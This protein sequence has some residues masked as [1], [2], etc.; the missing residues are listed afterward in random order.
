MQKRIFACMCLMLMLGIFARAGVRG[1]SGSVLKKVN[2]VE[3]IEKRIEQKFPY[4]SVPRETFGFV[5]KVLSPH[6]LKGYIKDDDGFI[7][8]INCIKFD[9]FKAE[10]KVV[11]LR[12]VCQQCGADFAYISYPSKS[13]EGVKGNRYGVN[14]NSEELRKSFLEGLDL[15]GV[16]YLDIRELLENDGYDVKTVFYKTDHHWT[17]ES[18]MYAANAIVDYLNRNFGYG[19]RKELLSKEKFTYRKY[20]NLWLGETGRLLSKTWTGALDD[21]TAIKPN[22]E[23]SLTVGKYHGE[24]K[25]HGDFSLLIDENGYSGGNDLYTYSAHYSYR[26]GGNMQSIHNNR[27]E[28][29][30]LLI[31]KDSFSVVVIPFLALT[32]SEVVSWDMRGNNQS[33][34]EFIRENDFDIVLLAY[35]DFWRYDMWG[36]K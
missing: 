14:S 32:M 4:K 15:Q 24:E 17:T 30:K 22:Y 31:I 21:F 6:M 12:N 9:L 35:T 3:E 13:N 28:G 5:S 26:C 2:P 25:K 18:G 8:P 34:Y 23:T 11:E 16:P 27:V 7:T 1:I 10:N 29:K 20:E 36:F 19:L 33:L